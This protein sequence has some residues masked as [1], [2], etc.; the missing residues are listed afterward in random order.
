MRE[1][2]SSD[3]PSLIEARKEITENIQIWIGESYI[4]YSLVRSLQNPSYPLNDLIR[5]EERLERVLTQSPRLPNT[6]LTQPRRPCLV[7]QPH[8]ILLKSTMEQFKFVVPLSHVIQSVASSVAFINY[9]LI[10]TFLL[11]HRL[12]STR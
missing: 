8:H 1:P 6:H 10:F 4:I 12:S 7:H 5:R 11:S 9:S 3:P 2:S